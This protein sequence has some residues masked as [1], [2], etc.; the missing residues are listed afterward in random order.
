MGP[1]SIYFAFNI[2]DS[3]LIEIYVE[4]SNGFN[5]MSNRSKF[6]HKAISIY[7]QMTTK[8]EEPAAG[9]EK[10]CYLSIFDDV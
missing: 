9:E 3:N 6:L 8:E 1:A 4:T 5:V 2:F 7:C 10:T